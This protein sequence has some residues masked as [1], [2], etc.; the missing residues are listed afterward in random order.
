MCFSLNSRLQIEEMEERHRSAETARMREQEAQ[1]EA[2]EEKRHQLGQLLEQSNQTKREAEEVSAGWLISSFK[3]FCPLLRFI[4]SSLHY[5]IVSLN[6]AKLPCF[7]ICFS[8][9]LPYIL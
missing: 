3:V 8:L 2:L 6:F 5:F 4:T 1:E 9:D 7:L